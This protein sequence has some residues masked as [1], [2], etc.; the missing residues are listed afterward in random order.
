MAGTPKQ[1]VRAAKAMRLL[2]RA[3]EVKDRAERVYH[4]IK[5]R[6]KKARW[7]KRHR[8]EVQAADRAYQKRVYWQKRGVNID[9]G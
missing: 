6:Q 2:Q 9:A 4:N 8:E 7:K 5:D 1:D 3:N